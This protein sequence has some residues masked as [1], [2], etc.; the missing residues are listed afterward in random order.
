[1]LLIAWKRAGHAVTVFNWEKHDTLL[2][3]W[4]RA[5]NAVI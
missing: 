3:D 5:G 4:E 1:M 2:F